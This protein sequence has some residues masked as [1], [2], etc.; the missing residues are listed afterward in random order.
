MAAASSS[1]RLEG[2]RGQEKKSRESQAKEEDGRDRGYLYARWINFF[3]VPKDWKV[4]LKID[5]DVF[6]SNFPKNHI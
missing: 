3:Q 1:R 2:G 5:R 6:F 4:G